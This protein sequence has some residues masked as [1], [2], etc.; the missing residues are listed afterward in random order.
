MILAGIYANICVC[1]SVLVPTESE[2]LMRKQHRQHRHKTDASADGVSRTDTKD[3]KRGQQECPENMNDTESIKYEGLQTTKKKCPDDKQDVETHK[4]QCLPES[5]PQEPP[6]SKKDTEVSKYKNIS[7]EY[8]EHEVKDSQIISRTEGTNKTK[9]VLSRT[10]FK[11]IKSFNLSL[12]YTNPNFI[13]FFICG[14]FIGL[15]YNAIVIYIAPK[16]VEEGMSKLKA[17]YIMSIVGIFQVCGRLLGGGFAD[18]KTVSPSI[19]CGIATVLA[20]GF[21]FMFPVNN[22]FA[23][24]A[25]VAFLFGM[26][27]GVCNCLHLLVAKEYVGVMQVSGAFGW[28]QFGK[29]LGAF[30]GIYIQGEYINES[31]VSH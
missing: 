31:R 19:A 4:Y 1:G 11:L 7:K 8:L 2:L 26:S 17:S 29:A 9:G 12:F 25:T 22:T 21:T 28:F 23:I 13:G 15:G 6:E 14:L 30:A 18:H 5:T 20:G 27:S 16:A 10:F 24:M 3:A